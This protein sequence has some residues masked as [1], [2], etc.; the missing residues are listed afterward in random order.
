MSSPGPQ[1]QTQP[2]VAAAIVPPSARSGRGAWVLLVVAAL[3]LALPL[4]VGSALFMSLLAQAMFAAVLATA[5]GALIRLNGVVS[6]GHAAFYGVAGYTVAL[7]LKHQW[8]SAEW[9]IVLAL[10]LPTALAFVLGLV[11]V[12]I[13][14]VA[15]SMLTLAVGQAFHEFAVKARHATGGD[16]GLAIRL[17]QH[18]FGIESSL[19]QRPHAAF[20]LAWVVLMVVLLGLYLLSRSKSGRLMEAIRENEERARFIGFRTVALRAAALAISAFIAALAGVLFAL[21]NG[22]VSPE[23]LHWSLSGSALIMAII[24]GPMLLWGP[25]LGAVIFFLVKDVAGTLTEH[26]QGVIGIT[27][28]LVTVYLPSGLGG[29]LARFVERRANRAGR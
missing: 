4:L 18:L 1:T 11:I 5:V 10:A 14:G 15:F 25:A 8:M 23:V 17:P 9:A 21:Y 29:T 6:F 19:L 3:G 7:A 12:R 27:L 16:D 13:P 26:W 20:V 22:F 2:Q 28:I 24:G